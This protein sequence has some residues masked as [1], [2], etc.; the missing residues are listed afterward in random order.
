MSSRF[1]WRREEPNPPLP[2]DTATEQ[3][4][5]ADIL[6]LRLS[7][8]E[9]PPEFIY[10]R[11]PEP[12]PE[13]KTGR[14]VGPTILVLLF[15]IS[16]GVGV[17]VVRGLQDGL[18]AD[19]SSDLPVIVAEQEPAKLR[20]EE[21]P[22]PAPSET[23]ES[24]A[25]APVEEAE[26]AP[27]SPSETLQR[28]LGGGR[29]AAEPEPE[30]VAPV[31]AEQP[32]AETRVAIPAAPEVPEPAA[33]ST[34]DNLLAAIQ[35]PEPRE[36]TPPAPAQ[37]ARATPTAPLQ[38][39]AGEPTRYTIEIIKPTSLDEAKSEWARLQKAHPNLLGDTTLELRRVALEGDRVVY[40][41]LAGYLPSESTALDFCA[42]INATDGG[43]HC[44]VQ[45]RKGAPQIAAA[46]PNQAPAAP[47]PAQDAAASPFV[48]GASDSSVVRLVKLGLKRAGFDPGPLDGQASAELSAAIEGYQRRY[49]LSVDGQPSRNLLDHMLGEQ[50][51]KIQPTAKAPDRPAP[52]PAPEPAPAPQAAAPQPQPAPEPAA[53]QPAA[54]PKAPESQQTAAV[55]TRLPPPEPKAPAPAPAAPANDPGAFYIGRGNE[56]LE[57]G[58]I[59]SARLFY[60]EAVGL[61]SA[62][63]K[64]ALGRTYDPVFLATTRI[65][66]PEPNAE[67]AAALYTEALEAGDGEARARLQEL[68]SWMQA[69]R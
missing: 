3:N 5:A 17:L 63:A 35:L 4:R 59:A 24:L 57:L 61:G 36:P 7:A 58:D 45:T 54:A 49:G 22:A 8:P 42:Q 44:E 21:P 10:Q 2:E 39:A 27:P 62:A 18:L 20:A 25:L 50:V 43:Q 47:E 46:S 34:T 15:G 41:G 6:S 66:G 48:A 14:W 13:R 16:L 12:T 67:M 68:Q 69:N 53:P 65:S 60:D 55:T 29:A 56:M 40:R 30:P 33:E 19:N 51:A 38:P 32:V 31:P 52:Q 9:P 11:R 23:S 28:L 26:E 64:T 37:E 1:P